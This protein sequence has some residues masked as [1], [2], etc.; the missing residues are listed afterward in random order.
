MGLLDK[1]KQGAGTALNKAQEGVHQ[2]KAKID[3]AQAKRQWDGLLT[4]L[5]AAVWAERR[6]GGP[7]SDVDAALAA[8][9]EHLATHGR[10]ED[11]EPGAAPP[12]ATGTAPTSPA[13]AP[14][15]GPGPVLGASAGADPGQ[16]DWGVGSEAGQGQADEGTTSSTT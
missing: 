14:A 7:S 5:G 10:V 8:L 4:K 16:A 13:P 9:D 2:G 3:Q 11:D 12:S 1:V 15:P 6:E